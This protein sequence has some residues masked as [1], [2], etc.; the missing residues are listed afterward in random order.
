[1]RHGI[2]ARGLITVEY[3]FR[4]VS[5]A[6][7]PRRVSGIVSPVVCEY[8]RIINA[9][10]R[11][12]HS[13]TIPHIISGRQRRRACNASVI[14]KARSA[15]R[16]DG[17]SGASGLSGTIKIII[18]SRRVYCAKRVCNE[19]HVK[20]RDRVITYRPVSDRNSRRNDNCDVK[21]RLSAGGRHS[22]GE[23]RVPSMPA[24]RARAF[25]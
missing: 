11:T 1:M 22:S 13:V 19:T 18:F 5:S 2:K 16:A 9:D 6:H 21:R 12:P 8:A 14:E 17:V 7:A 3:Q 23:M 24:Q 25:A 10:Y 20:H 4:R 15:K